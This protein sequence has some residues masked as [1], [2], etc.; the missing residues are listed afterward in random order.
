MAGSLTPTSQIITASMYRYEGGDVKW[1][2]KG[3]L[4]KP[5]EEIR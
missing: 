1:I 2:G 4:N 3:V 5:N